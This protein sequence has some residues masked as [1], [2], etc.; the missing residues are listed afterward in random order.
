[1]D[2]NDIHIEFEYGNPAGNKFSVTTPWSD[3]GSNRL[4]DVQAAVK[5]FQREN[6][7]QKPAVMH[8]TSATEALLL[9]N[10][11]M[12]VQVY[13]KDNGGRLVT[14]NDVQ[15]AFTALGLPNYEINDDVIVV[16]GE[17]RQLL[18][19]NKV[20]LL[21]AN[22]GVTMSGP[23]VENNYNPGKFVQPK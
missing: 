21:G 11:Q 1:D 7:R 19:D 9:Q 17:E 4:T 12:R 10:E 14:R 8:I 5:Q 2:V 22:L 23:T 3:T 18:E 15:A 16:N 13:G 6:Q 20:V